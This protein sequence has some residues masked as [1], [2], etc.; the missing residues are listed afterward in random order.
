MLFRT[1]KG[2]LINIE[3]NNYNNDRDYYRTILKKVYDIELPVDT[4]NN[5]LSIS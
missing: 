4:L 3:R 5:Y 2:Q 1:T